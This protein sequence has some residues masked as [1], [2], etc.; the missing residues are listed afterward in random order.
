MSH[1]HEC[2]AVTGISEVPLLW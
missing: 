2:T 1:V